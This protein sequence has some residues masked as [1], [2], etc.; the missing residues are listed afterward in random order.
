[1]ADRKRRRTHR[2][3]LAAVAVAC[4]VGPPVTVLIALGGITSIATYMDLRGFGAAMRV[5][6]VGAVACVITPPAWWVCA[7]VRDLPGERADRAQLRALRADTR[8][9][10]SPSPAR[11]RKV[12]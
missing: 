11:H 2:I 6:V 12:A 4:V 7:K 8:A 9:P 5:A 10:Q 1:V 3:A